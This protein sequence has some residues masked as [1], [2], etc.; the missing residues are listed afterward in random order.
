M[1]AKDRASR[2]K[3]QF[4]MSRGGAWRNRSFQFAARRRFRYD[5][6]LS[7]RWMSGLSRTPGKRVQDNILTGV[8]IPPSPPYSQESP[9]LCGTP[10]G[11]PSSAGRFPSSICSTP[12]SDRFLG[13]S[14]RAQGTVRIAVLA[15]SRFWRPWYSDHHKL[16]FRSQGSQQLALFLQLI[17]PGRF[18]VLRRTW[19]MISAIV[20]ALSTARG[21]AD[22]TAAS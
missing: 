21:L 1:G 3:S 7:E 20:S 5:A 18:L 11:V 15:P 13:P 19:R 9:P 6:P 14:Q 2:G 22:R 12:A 4:S 17:Q 10:A 16:N 8:R